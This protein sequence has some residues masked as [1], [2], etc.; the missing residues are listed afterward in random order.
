MGWENLVEYVRQ[1][2]S[3]GY[4]FD[5][6]RNYLISQGYQSE[7]IENAI[8]NALQ[9]PSSQP[10]VPSPQP[11]QASS[12]REDLVNYINQQL[13]AGYST[14]DIRSYL[15]NYGYNQFDVDNAI[16]AVGPVHM[17]IEHQIHIS[18]NTIVMMSFFFLFVLIS[19][20]IAYLLLFDGSKP[21][22]QLLD[23]DSILLEPNQK[24]Y[25]SN[26]INFNI[27]L[28]NF[29]S[30]K[31]YD[32]SLIHTIRNKET[33]R[34]ITTKKETVAV[35]VR[36]SKVAKIQLPDD[37]EPGLYELETEAIYE[38]KRAQTSFDFTVFKESKQE[39]VEPI[40]PV[41]PVKNETVEPK[42]PINET[43]KPV[44]PKDKYEDMTDKEYFSLVQKTSDLD[45]LGLICKESTRE[46]QQKVCY[47]MLSVKAK[48]D[49]NCLRLEERQSID[50]CYRTTA[51]SIEEIDMCQ[52]IDNKASRDLC[53]MLINTANIFKSR[54]V[55]YTLDPWEAKINF[56]MDEAMANLDMQYISG[57]DLNIFFS[58]FMVE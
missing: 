21:D 15:L 17:K 27:E 19:S 16:Q 26:V 40:E 39:P 53:K 58:M 3:Q 33:R 31:R 50:Y 23:L 5:Y 6:I 46:E 10:T 4:S 54:D 42:P 47:T 55:S 57:S 13:K 36:M 2:N 48:D 29:G 49:T 41:E 56:D 35:E 30:D 18:K 28:F 1:L 8:D 25:P 22:E 32:I 24:L 34:E 11:I 44:E 14:E 20:Y 52:K 45:S 43:P 9:T 37:I 7:D 38:Q 51:L 12:V